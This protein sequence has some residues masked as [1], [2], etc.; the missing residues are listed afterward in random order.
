M[1]KFL[2]LSIAFFFFACNNKTD[3]AIEYNDSIISLQ[4]RIVKLFNQLDSSFADTINHT[5]LN[6]FNELKNEIKN[7]LQKVDSFENFDGSNEFKERYKKLLSVYNQ[8]LIEDYQKL[9]SYYS[10]P[11][12]EFTQQIVDEFNNTYK[13][14]NEKIDKAL[15]DFIEFQKNFAKKYGF[16]LIENSNYENR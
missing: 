6:K 10:M 12:S 7:Q 2:F 13:T 4:Q 14:A 15:N 9:I 11:D 3:K 1:K 5:Y 8:V 16:T